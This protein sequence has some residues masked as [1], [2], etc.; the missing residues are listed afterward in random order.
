VDD[1]DAV[2]LEPPKR[3]LGVIGVARR[4]KLLKQPGQVHVDLL[5]WDVT[6]LTPTPPAEGVQD[7]ERLVRGTLV[8]PAP[9]VELVEQV[10]H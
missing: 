1:P 3:V 7:E 10:Q 9:D 6:C 8:A 5:E 4:S 2:V